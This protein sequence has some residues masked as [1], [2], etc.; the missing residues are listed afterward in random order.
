MCT[1]VQLCTAVPYSCTS[2]VHTA[3]HTVEPG[4][5]GSGTTRQLSPVRDQIDCAVVGRMVSYYMLKLYA[6]VRECGVGH[7]SDVASRRARVSLSGWAWG[8]GEPRA[9]PRPTGCRARARLRLD[10]ARCRHWHGLESLR[11]KERKRRGVISLWFVH[12]FCMTVD[13]PE[14]DDA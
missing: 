9:R 14:A 5:L 1:M 3:V 13:T 10:G 8:L 7:P 2:I 6:G 11:Y 4:C 12:A